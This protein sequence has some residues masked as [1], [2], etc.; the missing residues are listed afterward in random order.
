M[1]KTYV[2][3]RYFKYD[4]KFKTD[5][6]FQSLKYLL[7]ELYKDLGLF[8]RLSEIEKEC[9]GANIMLHKIGSMPQVCQVYLYKYHNC[10]L[11]KIKYIVVGQATQRIKH[12]AFSIIFLFMITMSR[13]IL[14]LM[15]MC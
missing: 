12:F 8:E 1:F 4:I 3:F 15:L 9:P 13:I 7:K 10:S 6:A 2:A 11:K 14:L 5:V